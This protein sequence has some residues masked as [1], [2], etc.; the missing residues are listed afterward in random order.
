MH[1]GGLRA[2]RNQNNIQGFSNSIDAESIGW[3]IEP[4]FTTPR[5]MRLHK[6]EKTRERR[7][8]HRR[9]VFVIAARC[10]PHFDPFTEWIMF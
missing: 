4:I 1:T 2:P 6:G 9:E 8:P 5:S 7:K 3:K 10:G